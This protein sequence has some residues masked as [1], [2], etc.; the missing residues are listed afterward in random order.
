MVEKKNKEDATAFGRAYKK[1][2]EYGKRDGK[3][4]LPAHL[5][6]SIVGSK[7]FYKLSVYH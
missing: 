2:S 4:Q 5:Q 6:N 3:V 1:V 7:Y